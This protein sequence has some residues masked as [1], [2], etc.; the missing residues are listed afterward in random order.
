MKNRTASLKSDHPPFGKAWDHRSL[1]GLKRLLQ[2][3]N[4]FT[5]VEVLVSVG[6]LTIILGILGSA[7]FKAVVT[8]R[9]VSDD[10]LAINE[11][12]KGL[13]WFAEDVK[14][15]Q[16][17]S[18][19]NCFGP[20]DPDLTLTW[21]E[22]KDTDIIPHTICYSVVGDRLLRIYDGTAHPAARHLVQDSLCFEIFENQDS[23]CFLEEI[24]DR[25]VGVS[26]QVDVDGTRRGLSVEAHMRPAPP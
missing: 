12:R 14:E 8:E 25:Y 3:S 20:G 1:V 26:F 5:L 15:A 22:Y 24:P 9:K 6:I 21:N 16:T 4:G 13:S 2:S 11:L 18:L 19:E 17:A 7:L 10:G 23:P